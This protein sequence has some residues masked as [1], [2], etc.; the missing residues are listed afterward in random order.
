MRVPA[1]SKFG[2]TDLLGGSPK[3]GRQDK[4]ILA[5]R[6]KKYPTAPGSSCWKINPWL[7]SV[8]VST[9]SFHKLDEWSKTYTRILWPTEL[10]HTK[11]KDMDHHLVRHG[12]VA[13]KRTGQIE[14][15]SANCLLF[16][17]YPILLP[18]TFVLST[19]MSLSSRNPRLWLLSCKTRIVASR[20]L[21]NAGRTLRLRQW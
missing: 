1:A 5:F 11:A 20:S 18:L 4:K 19:S 16:K 12:V 7:P 8:V 21:S 3:D 15:Q 14:L 2:G 17:K 10:G 9:V 13:A 6:I